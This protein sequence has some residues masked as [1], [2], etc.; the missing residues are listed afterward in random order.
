M[1][2]GTRRDGGPDAGAVDAALALVRSA[3]ECLGRADLD[4][5][6]A[7]LADGVVLTQ[8]P[9]LPWGGRF[10]GHDGVATFAITLASTIES[11]VT[12][13]AMFA[14]GEQVVQYGRTRGTVRATGA[15]FDIPECHVWTV[16]D[17]RAVEMA[18]FIDTQAMLDA[19]RHEAADDD[20]RPAAR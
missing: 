14:A 18:F 10:E 8:D 19:L 16:R 5:F 4:G 2:G 15:P 17:G 20:G 3:Y 1:S 12:V 13:E 6:L 11:K 7:L 9:A